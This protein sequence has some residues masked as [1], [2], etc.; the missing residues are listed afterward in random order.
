MDGQGKNVCN[1]SNF[2]PLGWEE[3]QEDTKEGTRGV[4]MK[5][6][7]RQRRKRQRERRLFAQHQQEHEDLGDDSSTSTVGNDPKPAIQ[8]REKDLKGDTTEGEVEGQAKGS[9]ARTATGPRKEHSMED[10]CNEFPGLKPPRLASGEEVNGHNKRQLCGE[11]K[12]RRKNRQLSQEVDSYWTRYRGEFQRPEEL[13]GPTKTGGK[14]AHEVSHYITQRQQ[15]SSSMQRGG[16]GCPALTGKPWAKAQMEEAVAR[17]PHVSALEP[18]A[19]EQLGLE[20]QEKVKLGQ[21]RLVD[22]EDI[23]ENPPK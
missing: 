18:D 14:C 12:E 17:G 19:I 1:E 8:Q 3:C 4:R 13:Q 16:G 22:W 23:Q 6:G 20:V 21:A 10:R 2:V 5:W 11:N 15:N 9:R 7:R